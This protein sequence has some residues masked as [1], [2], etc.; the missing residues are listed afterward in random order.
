MNNKKVIAFYLPQYHPIPEND[1]WWGKGF[2]EWTNVG[3]AKPLYKGH[4]QPKVPTELGY[5]DLRVPEVRE[6]QASLA[7]E[8]RISGFCYWHYWFEGKQLMQMPMQQVISTRK[9][10]FPFCVCWA[11]HSWYAKNWNIQDA[12][13]VHKLLIEQTYGGDDDYKAH[14]QSLLPAFKDVR[15]IKVNNKPLMGIYNAIDIPK[16]ENMINL[17]NELAVENGFDG[18][19]FFSY[20]DSLKK[21]DRLNKELFDEIVVDLLPDVAKTNTGI[22]SLVRRILI[23][24]DAEKFLPL[25]K[26]PYEKYAEYCIN[27]FKTNPQYSA[28]LIPNYDH[29]PRSGKA[30]IILEDS[31]PQAWGKLLKD[32]LLIKKN[33]NSILFVKSWNE[34]GEGNYLEPD[35]K[36]GRAFLNSTKEALEI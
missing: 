32:I 31:N 22:Y 5:Y 3:K 16:I 26:I 11:N 30:A 4:Y 6:E 12:K 2:T 8:A 27:F 25:N 34:W 14:F 13:R 33:D 35:I 29:S 18:I 23:K 36:Y 7:Q 17:W 9:P 10:N 21:L 15:Y 19:H 28:C 1:V 20:I 24:I